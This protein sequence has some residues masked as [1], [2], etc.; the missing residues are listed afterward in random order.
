MKKTQQS[1]NST[2]KNTGAKIVTKKVLAGAHYALKRRPIKRVSL[3]RKAQNAEYEKL[4]DRLLLMAGGK[5]EL[6]RQMCRLY[7]SLIPH[8]IDGRRGA[9]LI[10]PFNIIII[11][12]NAE[13]SEETA[14]HTFERIQELKKIVREIRIKQGFNPADYREE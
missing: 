14:H 13:H 9:R 3:K 11:L 8:H 10:D 7:D 2:L 4:R 6:S 1:F 12:E 5:S